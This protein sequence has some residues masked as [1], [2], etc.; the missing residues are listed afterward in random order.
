MAEE[1][2]SS[3]SGS[4]KEKKRERY[5]P[6]ASEHPHPHRRTG[7]PW[8][9]S[10]SRAAESETAVWHRNYPCRRPGCTSTPERVRVGAGGEGE[11]TP[12]H[13]QRPQPPPAKSALRP[14]KLA[15]WRIAHSLESGAGSWSRPGPRNPA[16]LP[17]FRGR[18]RLG[19]HLRLLSAPAR[20][21]DSPG[22]GTPAAW[23]PGTTC[24]APS[25]PPGPPLKSGCGSWCFAAWDYSLDLYH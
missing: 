20:N 3:S 12:E 18:R 4:L 19:R 6:L 16:G 7:T 14:T 21:W 13:Q 8:K 25:P 23:T 22:P 24:R 5:L 1:K 11:G 17:G 15:A 10:L 2:E 9:T